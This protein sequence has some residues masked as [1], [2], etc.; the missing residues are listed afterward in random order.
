MMHSQLE[1]LTIAT[2]LFVILGIFGCT[3]EVLQEKHASPSRHAGSGGSLATTAGVGGYWESCDPEGGVGGGCPDIGCLSDADC[4]PD[5]FCV[6][7][8][9]KPCLVTDWSHCEAKALSCE[10]L[11]EPVCGCDGTIYPN[12]C[13]AHAAGIN[14]DWK[15]ESCAPN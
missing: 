5:E 7:G 9:P 14:E 15:K 1:R 2:G 12:A 4:A 8:G 6:I 3:N 10:S 11:D 13:E